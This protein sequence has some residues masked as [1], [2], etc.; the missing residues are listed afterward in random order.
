MLQPIVEAR[1]PARAKTLLLVGIAGAS[2]LTMTLLVMSLRAPSIPPEGCPYEARAK[3]PVIR[4]AVAPAVRVLPMITADDI[5]K[6]ALDSVPA[7]HA[8]YAAAKLHEPKII[9][10]IA[11][12]AA[13]T[14]DTV[15]LS[16]HSDDTFGAC[17]MATLGAWQFHESPG[18]TFRF[19]LRFD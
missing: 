6:H 2:A 1:R 16:S 13:G 19:T 9:A 4:Q 14:V 12:A 5:E 7:L 15:Q 10:T 11:V 17:I 8:C 18:G 3:A